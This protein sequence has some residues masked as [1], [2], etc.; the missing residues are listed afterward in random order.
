MGKSTA[1]VS[2][3]FVRGMLITESIKA[4]LQ[5]PGKIN[6]SSLY[7]FTVALLNYLRFIMIRIYRQLFPLGLAVLIF[8]ITV[9]FSLSAVAQNSLKNIP[10]PIKI[11]S[12]NEEY[13]GLAWS[14]DRLY[15]LP[16]YGNHKET[17]LDGDFSL[18]S[19]RADSIARVIDGKDTALTQFKVLSVKNLDKLPDSIKMHYQGFEAITFHKNEVYLVIETD[20]KYDYCFII[21]GVLDE[22]QSQILIDPTRTIA[23]KRY[24]YIFNA[25]FES[26]TYLPDKHQL[27]ALFEFNG[28]HTGGIGFLIDTDFKSI[29]REIAVPYLPFRITDIQATERGRIYGINYY[30]EGDYNVYLN[31]NM[32]RNQEGAVKKWAPEL[33]DSLKTKSYARIVTKKRWKSK[34]WDQVATFE[35]N[36]TN[37]EGLALFRNG[38]L[39]ITDANRSKKLKTVFA[40]IEF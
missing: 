7:K 3:G 24:P 10:L 29:P 9:I 26:L 37:W 14:G 25:G 19:L 12:V 13:S 31:N 39:V 16:Q 6:I 5:F 8:L 23:L 40:F 34:S 22:Q 20:D 35:A 2:L 11:N 32:L 1:G 17:L 27:M 30:W 18:Y 28:M 15:L 33:G 21:K 36:K 4:K 38:A